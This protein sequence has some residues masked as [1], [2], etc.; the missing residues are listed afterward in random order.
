MMPLAEM[1]SGLRK[2]AQG[3]FHTWRTACGSP[4]SIVT[5]GVGLSVWARCFSPAHSG[6]R[7]AAPAVAC[8]SCAVTT[9]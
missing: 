7:R 6:T 3:R 8:S 9:C 5:A 2:V 4:R 1:T